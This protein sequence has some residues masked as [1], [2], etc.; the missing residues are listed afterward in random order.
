MKNNSG[1]IGL[2]AQLYLTLSYETISFQCAA[3]ILV[4][5][6]EIKAFKI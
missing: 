1:N 3:Y 6:F 5:S 4:A 2:R